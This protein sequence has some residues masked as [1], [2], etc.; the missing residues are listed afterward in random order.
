MEPA[1]KLRPAGWSAGRRHRVVEGHSVWPLRLE[2]NTSTHHRTAGD[3]P[4]PIR[5]A[6]LVVVL[7]TAEATNTGR[8]WGAPTA[9]RGPI[10]EGAV[11]VLAT[12]VVSAISGLKDN[13]LV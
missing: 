6:A 2:V 9:F 10:K 12:E 3:F 8:P 1:Y 7:G 11:V 5:E 13:L 4:G